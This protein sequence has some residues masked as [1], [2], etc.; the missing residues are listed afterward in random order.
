M[1]I[2]GVPGYQETAAGWIP[3]DWSALPL[4]AIASV[5]KDRGVAKQGVRCV[6][7]EHVEP[8]TGR[9]LGW[10]SS[11]V[12]ASIKTTFKRGDVLFGKLRP[13]LRKYAIAPFD[14]ICSTEIL[15]IHDRDGQSDNRFLFHLMQGDGVFATVKVLSYGTKM[16]R[17]SWTDLSDIVLGIP[18]L[19]EQQEIATILSA[20][21]DKLA[22]I[23]RQIEATQ[24]LKRGL[25]HTLFSRGV[26]TLDTGGRWVPHAE[27]KDTELGEIPA[28]WEVVP[29]GSVATFFNGRAYKLTEWE[30]TGTPVIR[31][32]NLT[33]SGDKYYY[34]NLVLPDHQYVE[35]GDLL[36]MWSATFGPYIWWGDKA[37]YHY[38][39]WKVECGERLHQG[40]MYYS[41]VRLTAAMKGK[42]HGST[43]M[44]LTK[45]GMEKNPLVLPPIGEQMRIAEVLSGVDSK[46]ELLRT[47]Q[48]HFRTLKR[49]LMQK[50]LTGE[51]LVSVDASATG[52]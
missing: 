50:L 44:H 24:A 25:M 4:G 23:A 52:T 46:I 32:Q 34:S 8:E 2:V 40:F 13:Y 22:V 37:I 29:Q 35:K 36:Y 6:E 47:R 28:G 11:G 1:S 41:L 7:L 39:I 3:T 12:Q 17:V 19:P 30:E 10:D 15:A 45:A 31:L 38:H 14:G 16:P 20:A 43:M 51:L 26:G 42:T 18:P 33:G 48:S 49:G 5:R 27:F 21:D 9:L